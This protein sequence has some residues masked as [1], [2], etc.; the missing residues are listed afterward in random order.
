MTVEQVIARF[1]RIKA[2]E[3]MG[4]AADKDTYNFKIVTIATEMRTLACVL[5]PPELDKSR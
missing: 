1:L 5:D 2:A 4:T 3:L